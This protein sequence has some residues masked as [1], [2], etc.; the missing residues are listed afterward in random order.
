MQDAHALISQALPLSWKRNEWMIRSGV[1]P[2][3][4]SIHIIVNFQRNMTLPLPSFAL[5][6][7]VLLNATSKKP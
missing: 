7:H 5:V 3:W 6:V 2:G 1:E 4:W